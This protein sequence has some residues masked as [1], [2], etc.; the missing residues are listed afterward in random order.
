MRQL[1]EKL[2][3]SI[4]ALVMPTGDKETCVRVEM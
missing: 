3:E 4:A 2:G 1:S